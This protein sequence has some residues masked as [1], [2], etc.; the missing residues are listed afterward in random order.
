[1]YLE[2][3]VFLDGVGTSKVLK[4]RQDEGQGTE[5]G[6]V[7]EQLPSVQDQQTPTP[8]T[9]KKQTEVEVRRSRDNSRSPSGMREPPDPMIA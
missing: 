8:S 6:I 9:R 7:E 5:V 1:V 4:R 3:T 2:T